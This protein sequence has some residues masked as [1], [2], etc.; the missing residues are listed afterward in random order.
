M[1]LKLG[2]DENVITEPWVLWKQGMRGCA[3]S[4]A[5]LESGDNV[6]IY[7]ATI[8]IIVLLVCCLC[9]FPHDVDNNKRH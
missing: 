4:A 8:T 7:L 6:S 3:R 1:K 9:P 5:T 2:L